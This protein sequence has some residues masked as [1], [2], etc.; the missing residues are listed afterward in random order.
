MSKRRPAHISA[1]DW[2]SVDAPELSAE[3]IAGMRPSHRRGPQVAPT[4]QQVT[5]RLDRDV[6]AR[7]R[8]QG[9]GWQSR[10]NAALRKVVG[11]E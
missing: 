10:I 3:F 1:E 9:P 7:F 4:K 6:V 11:I 5:I 8:A 2:N